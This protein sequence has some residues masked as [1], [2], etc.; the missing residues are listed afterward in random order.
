MKIVIFEGIDRSGKDSAIL[1][2]HKLTGYQY[3]AI[4]RFL[5][6]H[7]VYGR[8]YKRP[9]PEQYLEFESQLDLKNYFLVYLYSYTETIRQRLIDTK[10]T[11]IRPEDIDEITF[12][13]S[14]WLANTKFNRIVINT[15]NITPEQVADKVWTHLKLIR[16]S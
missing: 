6:S 12:Y 14:F 13:Y 10:E 5:G 8:L 16:N 9:N 4:N 15:S 1:A 7:Y 11:D 2:F 3:P